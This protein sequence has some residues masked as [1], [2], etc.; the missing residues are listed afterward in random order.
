MG[1]NI[2]GWRLGIGELV[3]LMFGKKDIG[4]RGRGRERERE[5]EDNTY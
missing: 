4:T 5:R 2:C 1:T 3:A